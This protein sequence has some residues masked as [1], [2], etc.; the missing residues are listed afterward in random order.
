MNRLLFLLLFIVF[1]AQLNAQE[2][3]SSTISYGKYAIGISPSALFNFYPGIQVSHDVRLWDR[4]AFTAET[5][6]IFSS[7][8]SNYVRGFR[9]KPGVQYLLVRSEQFALAMGVNYVL[10][11]SKS[12]R[13]FNLNYF[14]D[15]YT[16]IVQVDREKI[17]SGGEFTMS[18]IFGLTERL[19]L[20][21]GGG[22]G[23]G[24]IYIN[25]LNST[26]KRDDNGLTFR[27]FNFNFYDRAG[28]QEFLVASFNINL[29]YVLVK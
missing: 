4:L 1:T 11:Y 24:R 22:L 25:D 20:E 10:R 27:D 13:S 19:R 23:A 21:M 14:D 6:Y 16:E 3:D 29:S 15:N 28:K 5:G 26:Q 18:L 9:F 8:Y 2:S 7:A 17:I 12:P